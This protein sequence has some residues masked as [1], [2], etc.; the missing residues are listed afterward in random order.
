MLAEVVV[1]ALLIL[2]PPLVTGPA[3]WLAG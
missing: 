1:L 3:R 2:F